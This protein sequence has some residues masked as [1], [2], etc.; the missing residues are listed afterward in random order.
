MGW[1]DLENNRRFKNKT[2]SIEAVSPRYGQ[3][4][5]PRSIDPVLWLR[6]GYYGMC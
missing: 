1:Y 3:R 2:G 5:T 4:R 6:R